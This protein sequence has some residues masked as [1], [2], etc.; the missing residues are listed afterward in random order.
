M[1]ATP[2]DVTFVNLFKR[3]SGDLQI[4]KVIKMIT[5]GTLIDTDQRFEFTV[6]LQDG[7]LG[8]RYNCKIMNRVDSNNTP[9]NYNDDTFVEG[10]TVL[11][12]VQNGKIK[13]ELMHNQVMLIEDLP[14]GRYLLKETEVEGYQSS[15]GG[16]E[17]DNNYTVDP[18]Y[19]YTNEVTNHVCVNAF[20]VYYANLVVKKTVVTSD[21]NAE[22]D[23]AP[24]GDS[25]VFTVKISNYSNKVDVDGGF[26]AKFY[27]KDNNCQETTVYASNDGVITFEL[28]HGESIDLN[29]PACDYVVTETGMKRGGNSDN[30]DLHYEVDCALGTLSGKKSI[31]SGLT[32]GER[33]T[34]E[35]TNTYKQHCA[36]LVIT[37]TASKLFS[38]ND[39]FIFTVTGPNGYEQRVVI[40]GSGKAVIEDLPYGNYTVTPDSNWSKRYTVQSSVTGAV[41]VNVNGGKV[42]FT[43]TVANNKWLSGSD[44]AR[45]LFAGGNK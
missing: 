18:A 21:T 41:T 38:A 5:P 6:E 20:P 11:L 12:N 17:G 30:L 7:N 31:S 19:V 25:F 10:E 43:S 26:A 42:D 35:F 39:S 32:S 3:T 29:L 14:V 4:G 27:D 40:N 24:E 8:D 15:F 13:F 9:D 33:E 22:D 23:R 36:D 28:K 44:Y 34:V 2:G 37:N 16:L 1:A 45:N